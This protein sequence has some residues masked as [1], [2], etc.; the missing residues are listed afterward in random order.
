M[1]LDGIPHTILIIDN[2]LSIDKA[3]SCCG[4]FHLNWLTSKSH[5]T[6][7]ICNAC[8]QSP[9]ALFLNIS[10]LVLF[11]FGEAERSD[12]GF[13]KIFYG[14]PSFKIWAKEPCAKVGNC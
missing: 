2:I 1:N 12:A 3:E 8:M 6:S 10:F 11:M 13:G 4:N 5:G 7:I 9:T 14:R